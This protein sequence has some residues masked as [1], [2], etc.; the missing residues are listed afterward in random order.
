MKETE[1]KP[2]ICV[3][4]CEQRTGDLPRAIERAAELAD[5]I[6]LRLDYL[7][8]AELDEAIRQLDGLTGSVTR[9]FIIT[10]RPIEQGGM[11]EIDSL[12]RIVFWLDRLAR[13]EERHLLYD[14]ELD[15]ARVLMEK[16]GLDWNRIICSHHDFTGR[17]SN[18]EQLYQNMARTPARII[19]LAVRADDAT[20]CLAVF[21]LIERARSDGRELIAVAMGEAGVATRILGQAR[22]SFL[23]YGALDCEHATASGQQT[24]EELLELYRLQSITQATTVFGIMGSPVSHSLSP[25][26]QNAALG[27]SGHDAVYIPFEVR[28][29]AGFLRRMIHPR[30]REID[31]KLRGLS[32]TAPHKLSVMEQLD[33][34][35]PAAVEIGAVNTI[36]VEGESLRGYN[37]DA[38]GFLAPLEKRCGSLSGKEAAVIGSGGA[39]RSALWSLNRSGANAKLFARDA[40]K[41]AQLAEKF[42]ALFLELEGASFGD[43]Y[44]VVNATPLGTRGVSED[45]TPASA[46][47]L[48]GARLAYDLVYNPR[49]TRFLTEAEEAGCQT[50]TGLEMLLAQA[51]EQFRLWTGEDAPLEVM[52]A[53]AEKALERN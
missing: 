10:L 49:Q 32:V 21:N 12:N 9:P 17:D 47:Q 8:G 36:V 15:V 30:S 31:W 6:E 52:R 41:G 51:A 25:R 40:E 19:K 42:G 34:I 26:I 22:G 7:V 11:R 18:P 33:W 50:L 37:T 14:I 2:R 39:A 29:A 53:A 1:G 45:E 5:V 3:P 13:D 20:D 4:V 35:E 23:T 27:A 48:R 44:V 24:A 16:D 43:F 28:D 38:A 46:A